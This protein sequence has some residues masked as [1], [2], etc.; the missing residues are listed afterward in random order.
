MFSIFNSLSNN[1]FC[2]K[3]LGLQTVLSV[4]HLLGEVLF[5]SLSVIASEAN[6]HDLPVPL[7]PNVSSLVSIIEM[8]KYHHVK[9]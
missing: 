4:C 2:C 8:A 5:Q 6:K 3:K 9:D 7:G 1:T